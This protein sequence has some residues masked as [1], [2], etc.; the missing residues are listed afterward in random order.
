MPIPGL[1]ELGY[2]AF[3]KL[4]GVDWAKE[5]LG[6]KK[7]VYDKF[8]YNYKGTATTFGLDDG[9]VFE[10]QS[11]LKHYLREKNAKKLDIYWYHVQ[12]IPPAEGTFVGYVRIGTTRYDA[13]LWGVDATSY[14]TTRPEHAM[15]YDDIPI[16]KRGNLESKG[17]KSQDRSK[18]PSDA[19]RSQSSIMLAG[20]AILAM[21]MLKD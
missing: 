16:E 19:P 3:D 13:N 12:V 17:A 21:F 4:G 8:L 6:L 10:S 11:A 2:K 15:P 9:R 14:G 20:A 18:T 5:R 7:D 1:A